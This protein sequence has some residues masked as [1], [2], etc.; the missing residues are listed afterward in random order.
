MRK[1]LHLPLIAVALTA[2]LPAQD[3]TSKAK[4]QTDPIYLHNGVI[5]TVSGPTHKGGML[6]VAGKIAAVY[7]EPV[8]PKLPANTRSID[9]RGSH[10]YPGLV[11][12][13][14]SLGLAEIGSVQMSID[15]TEIGDI[16]PEV[17]ANIAVNADSTA[18]PV[19]RSNGILTSG[20]FPSGGLIAGRVSAMTTDG[21]TWQD[22][23]L[24]DD[25]GLAIQWPRGDR[26]KRVRQLDEVFALARAWHAARKADPKIATDLRW[27]AMGKVLRRATKAFILANDL[28]SIV[29]AVQWSARN[30]LDAVIIGGRDADMCADMLKRHDVEVVVSGTHSTPK[31]RDSHYGERFALP[32]RLQ[33]AGV[34]WCMGSGG[35]FANERNLPYQVASAVGFGLSEADAIHSIT[36]GAAAVLGVADRVGSL[37]PG[38]DATLIITNGSPLDLTTVIEI[39]FIQGREVDLHN[40]HKALADKYRAKY[41]QLRRN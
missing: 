9:L 17:R 27:Q 41:R 7:A 18:I 39:A 30:E 14:T 13:H 35:R 32:K 1:R 29:S 36:L 34:K 37:A 16:T 2:A 11:T 25:V 20:V 15:T 33:D 10:A 40:K 4:P 12:V 24:V 21:W 6:L 19:A 28:D 5:H 8:A 23:T 26:E 31:R 3:L 38:K 22:M